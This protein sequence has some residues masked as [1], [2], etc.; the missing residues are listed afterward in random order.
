MDKLLPLF[1]LHSRLLTGIS[2]VLP[3]KKADFIVKTTK[4]GQEVVLNGGKL[5]I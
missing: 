4:K 3:K 5:R 1:S 2:G